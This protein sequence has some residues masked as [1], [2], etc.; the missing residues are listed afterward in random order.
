MYKWFARYGVF[1]AGLYVLTLGVVLIIRASL[2]TS[3]ISSFTYVLSLFTPLSLGT[4]TF[5]LN[6]AL[7]AGQLWFVRG[8][9]TRQDYIEIMLQI[10]FSVLFSVFLDLNMMLTASVAPA[11]YVSA[12]AMLVAG[13]LVQALGVALELKPNVVAMSAEG[14]VK[15]GS[16][17]YHRSFGR[18]K[19]GFDVSLVLLAVVASVAMC[20]SVAGVREGTLVAAVSV[21][22]LVNFIN[23]RLLSPSRVGRLL[24]LF[25]LG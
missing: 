23:V 1:I 5:M 25:R 12:L 4:A 3:P 15:Y 2:G 24:S 16:R 13:C 8:I 20:G 14:F 11:G 21:G 6:L 18:F 22:L 17:R 19:V 9:G 7:I 10:P